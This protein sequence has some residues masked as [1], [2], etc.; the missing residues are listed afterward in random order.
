MIPFHRYSPE[1]PMESMFRDLSVSAAETRDEEERIRI[2]VRELPDEK[3]KRYYEQLERRLR[4]P[5][6]YAV[7]NWMFV[8]LHHI[9]LGRWLR[10][11][12]NL[13]LVTL[14]LLL[15]IAG[16]DGTAMVAGIVLLAVVALVELL[17]LFRSQTIVADYNNQ[18]AQYLLEHLRD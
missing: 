3:R 13:G 4:D 5:D 10:G 9:Y 1:K 7:L 2:T 18:Q 12:L 16:G 8:G 14:A 15:M 17:Q 11:L 6:T